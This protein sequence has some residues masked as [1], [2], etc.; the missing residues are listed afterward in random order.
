MYKA[1][2]KWTWKYQ[3]QHLT[4]ELILS[5]GRTSSKVKQTVRVWGWEGGRAS[6]AFRSLVRVVSPHLRTCLLNQARAHGAASSWD[7]LSGAVAS[8]VAHLLCP[9]TAPGTPCGPAGDLAAD[10]GPGPASSHAPGVRS[11]VPTY[12]AQQKSQQERLCR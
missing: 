12:A 4:L 7:Q 11:C 6:R 9:G 8:S 5:T 10:R 2:Q 1:Y 3:Q